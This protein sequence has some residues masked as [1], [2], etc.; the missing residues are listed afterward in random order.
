M[1]FRSPMYGKTW[2]GRRAGENNP[3]WKGGITNDMKAYM[4]EYDK[5]RSATPERKAYMREWYRKKK[6]E[7]QGV[8]TLDAFLK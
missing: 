5:K 2:G 6:A 4:K 8:G 3:N 7:R 1:L